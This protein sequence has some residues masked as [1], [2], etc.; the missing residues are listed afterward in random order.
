MSNRFVFT[1]MQ[2]L[3]IINQPHRKTDW[4]QYFVD[5]PT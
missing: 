5:V 2:C 3:K 4:Q 1:F